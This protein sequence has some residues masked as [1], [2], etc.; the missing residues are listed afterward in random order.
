MPET[1]SRRGSPARGV[2][3]GA[4]ATGVASPLPATAGLAAFFRWLWNPT[5]I[6]AA[7]LKRILLSSTGRTGIVSA[8]IRVAGM[9][10]ALGAQV[11]I[12]RAVGPS[13]FGDYAYVLGWVELLALPAVLG[14]G[15]VGMRVITAARS[16]GDGPTVVRFLAYGRQ[17]LSVTAL[18]TSLLLI[19]ASLACW[20]IISG[21]LL[22]A[23][24]ASTA[25]L[26]ALAILAAQ[27]G[28]VRGFSRTLTAQL[29]IQ[30]IRPAFMCLLGAAVWY[31]AAPV[32][33]WT[34]LGANA[35]VCWVLAIMGWLL[36]QRM[37]RETKEVAGVS[38][39]EPAQQREWRQACV[40]VALYLLA[41]QLLSSAP[42]LLTG[43]ILGTEAAGY[44]ASA[45]RIVQ[46]ALFGFTAVTFVTAPMIAEAH[47]LGDKVRVE[48]LAQRSTLA[49]FAITV[50][51]WLVILLFGDEI[52]GLQG[53]EFRAAYPAMWGIVVGQIAA[54]IF[55][56]PGYL[57][58]MTDLER[59]SMHAM[60]LVSLASA[61]LQ[62]AIL[63]LFGL[64]GAG[65]GAGAAMAVVN[66]SL[67]RM[68][69]KRLG[70][71]PSLIRLLLPTRSARKP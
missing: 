49:A 9:A 15:I 53:P 32:P 26:P 21:D 64:T 35:A 12:A 20:S 24:F 60:A 5:A 43:P 46:M 50:P 4:S 30:V 57:L 38:T 66:F 6:D 56:A 27:L 41:A 54:T 3:E 51:L 25:L 2:G 31:A 37:S 67:Y 13:V 69:R 55:G 39:A 44:Y 33:A 71:D 18:A 70:V 68:T 28:V 59:P 52:L 7:N 63:P 34:L 47:A 14:L 45:M 8:A 48:R 36:I 23:F 11:F 29:P 61:A 58:Q 40:A 22:K 19:A 10:M 1:Q 65:I 17:Q 16:S 62:C 42:L